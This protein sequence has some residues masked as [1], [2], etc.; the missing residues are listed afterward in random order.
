MKVP[1]LIKKQKNYVYTS[2][3]DLVAR[4][5]GKEISYLEGNGFG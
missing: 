4:H 1:A 5:L 3:K 2:N